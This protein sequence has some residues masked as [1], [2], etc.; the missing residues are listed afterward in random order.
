[1]EKLPPLNA[2]GFWRPLPR[3]RY[4][5][6]HPARLIELLRWFM[7]RHHHDRKWLH[8]KRLVDPTWHA[9]EHASIVQ[10]LRNGVLFGGE[11]GYSYCRFP[12]GP[13]DEEMG[14]GE[15]S[16]GVWFWPEGLAVY[17][18]RYHIRLLD[19]F[20]DH[21]IANA[22]QV[23]ANLDADELRNRGE[24]FDFWDKWCAS[25]RPAHGIPRVSGHGPER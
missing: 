6:A 24:S 11:C 7:E 3:Y 1:M 18:E 10:Y 8:P 16:D 4:H 12:D 2:I 14:S 22:F 17:V 23:L 9:S 25:F 20:A 13:P 15:L 19:E 5:R 21:I